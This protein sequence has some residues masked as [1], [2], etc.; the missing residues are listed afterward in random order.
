MATF[1][2]QAVIEE[3]KVTIDEFGVDFVMKRYSSGGNPVAG[4]AT[5]TLEA[6]QTLAGVILPASQG[7]LEAFDVRFITA[8]ILASKDVRFVIL[9]ALGHT[10]VPGPMDEVDFQGAVWQVMGCTPL[11][12]T[13]EDAVIFSIGLQRP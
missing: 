3:A 1:D 2:Y 4:T 11:N 7:T 5:K 12:V 9:S 13:G 10:F 6:T 8:E